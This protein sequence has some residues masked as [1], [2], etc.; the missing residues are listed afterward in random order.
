MRREREQAN[1][2]GVMMVSTGK[3]IPLAEGGGSICTGGEKYGIMKWVRKTF[4]WLVERILV[5][6][7]ILP[8]NKPR[9]QLYPD[10]HNVFLSLTKQRPAIY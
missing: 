7:V 8:S 5:R 6:K 10:D 4:V 1:K 3:S 9:R 2:E